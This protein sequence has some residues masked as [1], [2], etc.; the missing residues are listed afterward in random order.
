MSV[1]IFMDKCFSRLPLFPLSSET[2]MNEFLNVFKAQLIVF[3]KSAALVQDKM[4]NKKNILNLCLM[5]H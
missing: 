1:L 2:Q 3:L 4:L 5:L